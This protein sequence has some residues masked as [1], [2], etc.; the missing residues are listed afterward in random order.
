VS[1]HLIFSNLFAKAKSSEI[2]TMAQVWNSDNINIPLT[3]GASLL[4]RKE[5]AQVISFLTALSNN[6]L[7]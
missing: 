4:L 5:K 6:F 3:R 1:L 7:G 2:V